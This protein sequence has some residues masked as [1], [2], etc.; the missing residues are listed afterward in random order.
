MPL[1]AMFMFMPGGGGTMPRGKG[2]GG[3]SPMLSVLESAITVHGSLPLGRHVTRAKGPNCV[4]LHNHWKLTGRWRD[5]VL[6]SDGAVSLSPLCPALTA[7]RLTFNW[8]LEILT[9]RSEAWVGG[10]AL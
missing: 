6:R 8:L 5:G 4:S 2:R 10:G 3:L 7:R 1:M 9:G